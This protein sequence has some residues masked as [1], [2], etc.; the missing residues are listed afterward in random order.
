M[1]DYCGGL[2]EGLGQSEVMIAEGNPA[3]EI[4]EYLE[5]EKFDMTVVG[6]H[7]LGRL[8][9]ILLGSTSEHI[10][11]HAPTSVLIVPQHDRT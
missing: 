1:K 10:L 9:R 11:A 4:L 8:M 3:Q 6:T 5:R 7:G 2:P